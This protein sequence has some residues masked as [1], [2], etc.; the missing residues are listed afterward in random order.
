MTDYQELTEREFV[1]HRNGKAILVGHPDCVRVYRRPS[2]VAVMERKMGF[3]VVTSADANLQLRCY[4]VLVASEFP[5][6]AYYGCLTQPRVSSK[7]QIVHY[8][9]ADVVKARAEIE[10]DYDA[11]YVPDAPRRASS[12]ACEHCAARL[13]QSCPEHISWVNAV[14]TVGRLPVSAWTDQQMDLFES[15]RAAAIKFIDDVH[16][17]I[18]QIKAANPE[19]L[20]GWE[21][22]PGAEV[23]TCEDL[24]AAWIALQ[25]H[26]T[27]REFSD[28]CTMSLGAIEETIWRKH[29]ENPA[30]GK[31]SQKEAKRLVNDALASV[32]IKRRNKPSLV[33][34]EP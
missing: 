20:P 34:D 5:A 21:L 27:A 26:L 24:V 32:L 11:C 17:Q 15:R 31:L 9:P 23:R 30:L 4:I 7:P 1:L 33:K 29:R 6:V 25:S 13:S 2:V 22:R 3:K 12:E 16:E 14:Q 18:K 8:T 10:A 19:R 28:A